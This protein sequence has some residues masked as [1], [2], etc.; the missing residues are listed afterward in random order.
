[1]EGEETADIHKTMLSEND[2]SAH[3]KTLKLV[4]H[5]FIIVPA[6]KTETA[7][8]LLLLSWITDLIQCSVGLKLK[9]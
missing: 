3:Q 7:P 9:L 5:I 2:Q 1:M 8:L 4:L 6:K